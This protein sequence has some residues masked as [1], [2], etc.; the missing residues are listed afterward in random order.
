MNMKMEVLTLLGVVHGVYCFL[1]HVIEGVQLERGFFLD[2]QSGFDVVFNLLK[3]ELESFLV[4][5]LLEVQR[6][7]QQALRSIKAVVA[8][9]L[10]EFPLFELQLVGSPSE[11][12]VDLGSVLSQSVHFLLLLFKVSVESE[13]LS[14]QVL[15]LVACVVLLDEFCVVILKLV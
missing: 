7:L 10:D 13:E 5:L 12:P 3:L 14:F 15:D 6:A 9:L 1:E 11:L 2:S 8:I 4:L